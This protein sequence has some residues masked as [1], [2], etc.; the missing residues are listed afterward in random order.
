MKLPVGSA[1]FAIGVDR[2]LVRFPLPFVQSARRFSSLVLSAKK[3]VIAGILTFF[4]IRPVGTF[5]AIKPSRKFYVLGYTR[6]DL[7]TTE[8][9]GNI[10]LTKAACEIV[11]VVVVILVGQLFFLFF[12]S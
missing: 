9:I 12:F 5:L 3:V 10:L 2:N 11:A 4:N 8:P 7:L 1:V 6:R